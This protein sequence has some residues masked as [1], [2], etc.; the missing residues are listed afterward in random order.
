V[1]LDIRVEPVLQSAEQLEDRVLAVDQ[2]GVRLLGDQHVADQPARDVHARLGVE[3]QRADPG[4]VGDQLRPG[5][6]QVPVLH[7]VVDPDRA[8]VVHLAD[9]RVPEVLGDRA[10]ERQRY[11]ERVLAPVGEIHPDQPHLEPGLRLAQRRDGGRRG[12]G[13]LPTLAG[14]PPLLRQ[15]L[16]KQQAKCV[17]VCLTSG[18]VSW[19]Q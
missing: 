18:G 11:H 16:G 4:A 12:G 14:K 9:Q 3:D 17:H 15:P 8:A 10:A 19:N 5:S 13:D 2:R 1:H 7:P 6:G